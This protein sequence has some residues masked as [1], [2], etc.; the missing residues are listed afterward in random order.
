MITVVLF[1][2]EAG[3]YRNGAFDM[4]PLRNAF[5]VLEARPAVVLL[6]EAKYYRR[7]EYEGLRLAEQALTEALDA[8]Y[9]GLLG[10]HQHGP[11]P[12]AIFY[13]TDLV[14]NLAWPGDDPHDPDVF[15]DQRNVGRFRANATGVE[16]GAWVAHF[17]ARSGA[18]RL[19]EAKL[20]D[21]YGKDPL[22]FVGGGD[23]NSTAS[24]GHFPQRDWQAANHHIRTHKG[25]WVDDGTPEGNW[26]ADT[27]ALDH[28]I[29]TWDPT[30][31]RRREGSGYHAI[32]ELAWR[33]NPDLVIAP[34]IIDK[35]GEGGPDLID[36]LL[37]N[38]AMRPRVVASSYQ[39]HIPAG[40]PFPSD[41]HLITAE[42]NI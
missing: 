10:V 19:E 32:A 37:V 3:G 17:N 20:L 36:Y 27:D 9:T 6:C 18:A 39:V 13:N 34:S 5:A 7:N 38:D 24:G 1:N 15:A 30:T 25:K 4:Q 29:G 41:H 42:I 11:I 12:P 31:R 22:P 16:F 14:T 35:P 28:L 2:F 8:P 23:L 33:D 21:R 26:E 40:P